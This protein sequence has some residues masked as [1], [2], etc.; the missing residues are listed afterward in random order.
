MFAQTV[1]EW[2]TD[3]VLNDILDDLAIHVHLEDEG[4]QIVLKNLLLT[5]FAGCLSSPIAQHLANLIIEVYWDQIQNK[6]CKPAGFFE[7]KPPM[8]CVQDGSILES[9]CVEGVILN[10]SIPKQFSLV[11]LKDP[12]LLVLNCSL[13]VE[14]DKGAVLEQK[15]EQMGTSL[16]FSVM[17]L[18]EKLAVLQEKEIGMLVCT[19]PASEIALEMFAD[20]GI[21]LLSGLQEESVEDICKIVERE[22]LTDFLPGTIAGALPSQVKLCKQVQERKIVMKIQRSMAVLLHWSGVF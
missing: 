5:S 10:K 18:A 9:Y 6:G 12:L 11:E 1:G 13:E 19:Y 20:A 21:L 3:V 15:K 16:Q 7:L 17:C 2:C 8:F 4:A 14:V 22:A